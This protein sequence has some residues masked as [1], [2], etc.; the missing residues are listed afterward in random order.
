MAQSTDDIYA[1]HKFIEPPVCRICGFGQGEAVPS[2]HQPPY[3]K[4]YEAYEPHPWTLGLDECRRCGFGRA[5]R[6]VH[7]G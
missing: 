3:K 6:K 5:N 2:L 4:P 7:T 1:P